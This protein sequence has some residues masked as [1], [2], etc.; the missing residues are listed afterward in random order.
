M[1]VETKVGLEYDDL[2]NILGKEVNEGDVLPG[3]ELMVFCYHR[4]KSRVYV[5]AREHILG[6]DLRELVTSSEKKGV[7]S[8]HDFDYA[9]I[10]DESSEYEKARKL[11][12]KAQG[13]TEPQQQSLPF[14]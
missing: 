8:I 11:L 2:E 4:G 3:D 1:V 13:K 12:D 7:W 6:Y 10:E 9:I 14:M 5:E